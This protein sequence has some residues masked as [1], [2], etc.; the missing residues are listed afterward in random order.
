MLGCSATVFLLCVTSGKQSTYLV[1]SISPAATT[2]SISIYN[3]ALILAVTHYI[4]LLIDG[5]AS[6]SALGKRRVEVGH[7]TAGP[8]MKLAP[9]ASSARNNILNELRNNA[10][11][12]LYGGLG[13]T[14]YEI[15]GDF[16]ARLSV[17][18]RWIALKLTLQV[19]AMTY[20]QSR[21]CNPS[22]DD[23]AI[24]LS[25]RYN[26]E[27]KQ[28]ISQAPQ[29]RTAVRGSSLTPWGAKLDRGRGV[30]SFSIQLQ[31][32][33]ANQPDLFNEE[34]L[35][36][37]GWTR[38]GVVVMLLAF[39]QEEPG[40]IPTRVT[41]GFPV[42]GNRAGRCR[43]PAGFLGYLPVSPPLHSGAAPYSP[44]FTLTGSIGLDVKICPDLCTRSFQWGSDGMRNYFGHTLLHSY[45]VKQ[46]TE[47]DKIHDNS[48]SWLGLVLSLS[49][50]LSNGVWR[51]KQEI[52]EKTRRQSGIVRHDS[53]M[54]K[55]RECPG[56]G[57]SPNNR[58]FL[59]S[60]LDFCRWSTDFL[61][62][63][64]FSPAVAVRRCSILISPFAFPGSQ[65]AAQTSAL[66]STYVVS[67]I[68]ALKIKVAHIYRS[69]FV[70]MRRR[71]IGEKEHQEGF[72]KV[73]SNQKLKEP[74]C[75]EIFPAF[76]FEKHGS[77]K[78][79]IVTRCKCAIAATR[80]TLN[81]R[82][83]LSCCV[84]LQD[85]K[86]QAYGFIGGKSS[87]NGDR[88]EVHFEPPKLAVRNL[89]PRSVTIV[90]KLTNETP[91]ELLIL[92]Q[93]HPQVWENH[94][95]WKIYNM[96]R[97]F[98]VRD[99]VLDNIERGRGGVVV[100]LLAS[101][102]CEPGSSLG[103]VVPGFS[104]VG[105][106]P[107][108]AAGWQV[109]T[110]ISRFP[111]PCI[112][113]L[114]HTHFSSP[115]SALK[116]SILR[117]AQI[118]SL[119]APD[120]QHLSEALQSIRHHGRRAKL[121]E[122]SPWFH[123]PLHFNQRL[124]PARYP[125]KEIG[126]SIVELKLLTQ[127]FSEVRQIYFRPVTE[128]G[129]SHS[130]LHFSLFLN[131]NANY[132]AEKAYSTV[133]YGD[134]TSEDVFGS[135]G[136]AGVSTKEVDDTGEWPDNSSNALSAPP[137]GALMTAYLTTPESGG[138]PASCNQAEEGRRCFVLVESSVMP[139]VFGFENADAIASRSCQVRPI[140]G[141]SQKYARNLANLVKSFDNIA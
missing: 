6:S 115:S 64:L 111:R 60:L 124:L 82:A 76:E 66:H 30:I 69:S 36:V 104:H 13:V 98:D 100:R 89:D 92:D 114:L 32:S 141:T 87:W 86:R 137:V 11:G 49:T 57:L 7:H 8:R 38:G 113:S 138:W 127:E 41:P 128:V 14:F 116:T 131:N 2:I 132:A 135:A 106:V 71:N 110:G 39:H 3:P 95:Q 77:Y 85:S 21:Q 9:R 119:F 79:N 68:S 4:I 84:Y 26:P 105:I 52:P 58:C 1:S 42:C 75:L 46:S 107:D 22:D 47:D 120:T 12:I 54:G 24:S 90:D 33:S 45:V 37:S 19:K 67:A 102:S 40:S 51:G 53:H 74:V 94:E 109:F 65:Q 121:A 70:C 129:Q 35:F 134:D 118:S 83:A 80:K 31:L 50:K 123:L 93:I 16:A 99:S 63:L 44:R 96:V 17:E 78:G 23:L 133:V 91:S 43:W 101:H 56:R 130:N 81:W 28:W 15:D 25:W 10:V 136:I 55:I 61:G 20:G 108:D 140:H 29:D 88:D 126:H 72:R 27:S 112:L 117:A 18:P 139:A 59:P 62:D 5:A 122:N 73:R 34:C 103:G 97:S 48:S 125:F